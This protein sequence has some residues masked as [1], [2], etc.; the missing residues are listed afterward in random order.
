MAL[1]RLRLQQAESKGAL[2]GSRPLVA[3]AVV[4]QPPALILITCH[5]LARL[6]CQ[7]CTSRGKASLAAC[8][9]VH[10]GRGAQESLSP[11]QAFSQWPRQRDPPSK[12]SHLRR[13]LS[14]LSHFFIPFSSISGITSQI[15]DLHPNSLLRLCFWETQTKMLSLSQKMCLL[16]VPAH[17]QRICSALKASLLSP[18]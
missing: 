18:F 7:P 1:K 3:D 16:T 14:T 17:E 13:P 11:G 10:L 4:T 15:K 5:P 9:H 12:F 2:E 6:H 8:F